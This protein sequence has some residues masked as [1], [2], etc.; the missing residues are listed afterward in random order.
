MAKM[1]R[2]K[3]ETPKSNK[4]TIRFTDAEYAQLK[5][6]AEKNNQTVAQ[7]IRTGVKDIIKPDL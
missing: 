4:V 2:P 1:G 7:T 5:K 6:C 3:V